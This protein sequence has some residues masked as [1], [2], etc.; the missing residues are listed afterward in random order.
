[1]Y[2]YINTLNFQFATFFT[3][4]VSSVLYRYSFVLG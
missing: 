3:I 2:L 1:M 4:K